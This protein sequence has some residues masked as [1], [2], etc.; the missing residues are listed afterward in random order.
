[1][2]LKRLRY[3]CTYEKLDLSSLSPETKLLKEVEVN[4][5]HVAYIRGI[6]GPFVLVKTT[7][8]GFV[9]TRDEVKKFMY[10]A[11]EQ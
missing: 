6:N 7:G 2:K 9:T 1:M 5:D 10:R 4:P 8:E 11:L 3:V